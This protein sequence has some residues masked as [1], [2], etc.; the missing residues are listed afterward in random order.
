MIPTISVVIPTY[1]R[2]ELIIEAINSV[3][4]Q[5]PKN[6]EII[7]V[8]D[9]SS[10]GT[11]KYLESLN[12][13]IKIVRKD[14][15]GV[16]SARNAGIKQAQG[17]YIA[18]LDS[19]DLWLPGILKAQ[20]DF[21]EDNPTIPLVYVDEFIE[22]KG[23]RIDV[24]RFTMKKLT[25]EEM[26]RFDLPGFAQSPPIHISS[27]MVRK[28]IFDEL[29]YFNEDLQ[30]HEDTDMWNRISEKY[31][32]GYI[33]K[34]FAVFRWEVDLD[35]L[36]KPSA[37]KFF[38]SEGRKYLTFYED[39]RKNRELTDREKKG[40]EDSYR[41]MGQLEKLI[42]SLEIG[43]ITEEEFEEKQQEISMS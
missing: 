21:L 6:F 9:G 2:R 5:E 7:V 43:S 38:I 10:D 29:G 15:G 4:E 34:P 35:H 3:L 33:N 31:K 19:D 8:D 23:K 30:I 25:H 39:R 17:K 41:R 26:S 18:F 32:L 24:T 12:L 36:L 37:R 22:L 13:P 11:P 20:A 40:I 16:S 1:N 27:I 28:Y 42:E 14:N